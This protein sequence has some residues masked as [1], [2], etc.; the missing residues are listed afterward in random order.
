MAHNRGQTTLSFGG[1]YASE[2]PSGG[3]VKAMVPNEPGECV[4]DG[5]MHTTGEDMAW[6]TAFAISY[7]SRLKD[8]TP[9]NLV[10]F[11]VALQ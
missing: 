3:T 9:Q 8:V 4:R 1:Q 6:G 2:W 10:V 5:V 7:V 11:T